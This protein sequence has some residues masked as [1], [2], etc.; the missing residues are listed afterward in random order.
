[1]TRISLLASALT[2][3]LALF[4]APTAYA[5]D[6]DPEV[7]QCRRDGSARLACE[8]VWVAEAQGTRIVHALG[9]KRI[10]T[11]YGSPLGPGLGVL[12]N[13][14]PE[15]M[16][17]QLRAQADDYRRLD[18]N[19]EVIPAFHIVA[20]VAD[21][22]AGPDGDYN[23]RLSHDVIRQWI[24]WAAA[25]GVWVILD[26]Q[27][28]RGDPMAEYELLEPFLYEP[29]VHLAIDP[30]FAVGA[31]GIP[32][33]ELG[34]LDAATLNAVQ[35]RLESIARSIG[36]TKV[37][38]IHQFEDRMIADK[39]RIENYWLVE[40]VWDSDGVGTPGP[41]IADYNQYRGERGFEKGGFKVFYREDKPAMTPEQ[42]MALEPRPSIIVYQ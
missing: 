39:D 35:A 12:G 8:Q 18:P 25:E 2:L 4:F 17:K 34:H 36:E 38:M 33:R 23:H 42:V 20:V 16:L 29:H 27:P 37:L 26:I 13:S 22:Y 32:G 19:T 41:K 6:P 30:E 31:E 3:V 15:N 21:A 11:F 40:L 1:M 14:A 7:R 5:D 10:V 9:R 28:G 24:D